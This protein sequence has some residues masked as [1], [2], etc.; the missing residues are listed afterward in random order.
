MTTIG[1]LTGS[2]PFG[3]LPDNPAEELLALF[4][5]RDIGGVVLRTQLM[6]VSR[7]RLPGLIETLVAQHRPAF[8]VSLGLAEFEI[9]G[10]SHADG[11]GEELGQRTGEVVR[12]HR[13]Q[14]Q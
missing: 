7:A 5:G 4:E 9:L 10:W 3:G 12:V 13:V 8:V 14:R 1:L 2:A 6:P 11:F